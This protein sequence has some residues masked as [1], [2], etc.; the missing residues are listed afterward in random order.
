MR[1]A[2]LCCVTAAL[3][4]V[5]CTSGDDSSSDDAAPDGTSTS[6]VA[7][8][9][10]YEPTF[11]PGACD[12][13]RVP[14]DVATVEC[15]TLV[16][17][18][19][20]AHPD[21]ASVRLPVAIVRS[22]APD[23]RPDPIVYFSG[24][25]GYPGIES[26]NGFT[27]LPL[28]PRRDLIVFD[29]RGT[30]KAEPSLECPEYDESTYQLFENADPP[31]VEESRQ[32]AAL[33]A[34]R[35]RL[36]AAGIDLAQ[37]DT[38]ATAADVADLR[39]ALGIDEWNIFGISYGTA[40]ALEVLRSHPEGV[41]SAVIDS[42]V[43]PDGGMSFTDDY[44]EAR[45]V[46]ATLFEGC[47]KDAACNAAFPDLESLLD[48][49]VAALDATPYVKAI[50]STS[51]PLEAKFTGPDL[52]AGIW[53]AMY[54]TELIPLIPFFINEVSRGNFTILDPV[55]DEGLA[56]ITGAA[57][58]ETASVNCADQQDSVDA[59]ELRETGLT[60]PM[61]GTIVSAQPIPL[62]CEVWDVPSNEP[63]FHDIP[64]ATVPVLVFGDEYDPI[65]PPEA[66]EHTA[67]ELGD[68]AT[69]V[70]FPGLGHGATDAHPCPT[71]IFQAFVEAP[72]DEVDVTCVATMPAPAFAT[73]G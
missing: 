37:Y 55:A 40:V 1:R 8:A 6:I 59:D 49:A 62:V 16:V 27:K 26:S 51:R 22:S 36:L 9:V 71:S 28:D 43:P 70:F 31:E 57:E 38:P 39:T 29:Q 67:T 58:G 3:V 72:A 21:D 35:E 23:R 20:R 68:L 18:E 25:P 53:N 73:G 15:G 33:V 34:C 64:D 60:E 24:G 7:V 48:Q 52:V 45:R 4:M 30:G 63:S 54:D 41:R 10:T 44:H 17:P 2:V 12:P 46:F 61:F 47:A 66:S 32:E 69:F 42:V 19:D 56:F 65:T 14:E 50:T 5:G 11:E 13:A